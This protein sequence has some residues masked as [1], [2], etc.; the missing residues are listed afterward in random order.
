MECFRVDESGY[1][2]FD[3]LNTE[4]RFQGASAIA[5]TDDD[6]LR[7]IKEYFPRLQAAELKYRSVARR[8]G[9]RERLL[10]LQRDLLQHYKCVTYVCLKRY[11]HW[12][13]FIDYA[14]EPYYHERN[15]D[16]YEDG[17]N[18]AMASLLHFAGESLLGA[19]ECAHLEAAFQHAVHV[20][21]PASLNYLVEAARATNYQSLP[22]VMSPLVLATPSCLGAIATEGVNTDAAFVVL[23]SLINRL[24]VIADGPYWIE[25]DRSHN[26][27]RYHELLQQFIG[28]AQPA[29]FRHSKE[30]HFKFPLKLNAVTQVDS[31][32]SPAVQLADVL[33]GAAID[34]ANALLDEETKEEGLAVLEQYAH[35]QLI[36]MLPSLD[37]EEQKRFR[38]GT[39]A[40]EMI[41]Y[42][43]KNFRSK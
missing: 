25:H 27:L 13:M 7:L 28:H 43:S 11:V 19:K 34:A 38:K 9:N 12:L 21:T 16:F 31:K 40:G 39:Q 22:E 18:Y 10:A 14:V 37:F 8:P 4:Q 32:A 3:L 6:A 15:Y 36:S 41:N 26:L 5:I 30:A 33:I 2:G 35:D 23:Q 24:E 20:K 17:R 42:F 29:E 1:T